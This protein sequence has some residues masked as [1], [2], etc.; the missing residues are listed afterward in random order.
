MG[1][2]HKGALRV[3]SGENFYVEMLE[4]NNKSLN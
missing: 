1:V 2:L 4:L 3:K